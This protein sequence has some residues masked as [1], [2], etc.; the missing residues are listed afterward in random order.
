MIRTRGLLRLGALVAE[1]AIRPELREIEEELLRVGRKVQELVE[2]EGSA[3]RELDEADA[4]AGGARECAAL[5]AEQLGGDGVEVVAAAERCADDRALRARLGDR[6]REERLAG[7]RLAE[8]ED[9]ELG[10][11]RR[12]DLVAEAADAVEREDVLERRRAPGVG[13]V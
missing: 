1:R 2:D 4:L 11:D 10:A 9:R 3:V 6:L 7:A 12:G 8:N 13:R 5:V